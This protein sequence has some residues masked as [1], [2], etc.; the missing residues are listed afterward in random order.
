MH[1]CIPGHHLET[2]PY[3]IFA[4]TPPWF[5][6]HLLYC[7]IS[8]LFFPFSLYAL[9]S[10]HLSTILYYGPCLRIKKI[11]TPFDQPTKRLPVLSIPSITNPAYKHERR[12][13]APTQVSGGRF[14]LDHIPRPH[15]VVNENEG[16][17]RLIGSLPSDGPI[18]SLTSS[19]DVNNVDITPTA[20]TRAAIREYEKCSLRKENKSQ[21]EAFA[22]AEADKKW[23]TKDV[24][25]FNCNKK[26]HFKS[27]CW[28]KGSS[29]EGG[30]PKR[31]QD[32]R[33]DKSTAKDGRDTANTAQA[34]SSSEDESWAVI[35]KVGD[36]TSGESE[37]YNSG[38]SRHMSPFKHRLRVTNL[39]SIPPCPITAAN[40]RVF[41]ATGLGDLKIDVPNNSLSTR[42]TLKDAL[43]APDMSLT[44]VT[45][46]KIA[47]AG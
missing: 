8:R 4:R 26:G 10:P 29:N 7:H 37:L 24:E 13:V 11:S 42:I 12:E 23:S 14:Q 1:H 27:E 18:D 35:V 6:A 19:C 20:V 43:Y 16:P 5:R 28:A 25:C 39:S 34:E 38:A 31:S 46:S 47:D 22:A 30:G 21:D 41:Y 44:V 15:E 9:V 17:W 2:A 33:R 3:P 36:A 45:I 40:N 32:Q